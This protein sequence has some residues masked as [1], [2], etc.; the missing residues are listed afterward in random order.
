MHHKAFNWQDD[1]TRFME[2]ILI[3][4]TIPLP[5]NKPNDLFGTKS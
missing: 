3:N 5:E 1:L 2:D 4:L